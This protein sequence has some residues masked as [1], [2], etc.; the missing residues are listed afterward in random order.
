MNAAIREI[1][2]Y[3]L[4]HPEMSVGE[5]VESYFGEIIW[6][7]EKDEYQRMSQEE[8]QRFVEAISDVVNKRR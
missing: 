6:S 7:L 5:A 1:I 4:R 2:N 3:V 8:R